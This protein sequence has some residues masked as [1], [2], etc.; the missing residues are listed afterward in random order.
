MADL[1]DSRWD[2]VIR[3]M[4]DET[5]RA[6]LRWEPR[7]QAA[8]AALRFAVRGP[9][10]EAEVNDRRVVV[11]EHFG[12][13]LVREVELNEGSGFG[14]GDGSYGDGSGDGSGWGSGSSYSSDYREPGAPP[15][16]VAVCLFGRD[17]QFW[18]FPKSKYRWRLMESIQARQVGAEE[19]VDE[20]LATS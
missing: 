5:E 14:F 4:A 6:A 20:Y 19:F 16:E 17:G 11:F 9:V 10:Y 12:E 3:K 7:D 8:I 13:G 15:E 2:R 18:E 1:T